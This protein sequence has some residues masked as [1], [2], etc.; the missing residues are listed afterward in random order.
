VNVMKSKN[1][2][3]TRE[4]IDDQ[5]F[6]TAMDGVRF[7]ERI[8]REA[9][10]QMICSRCGGSDWRMEPKCLVNIVANDLIATM[11]CRKCKRKAPFA[12]Y[13]EE[14]YPEDEPGEVDK[15]ELEDLTDILYN[16]LGLRGINRFQREIIKDRIRQRLLKQLT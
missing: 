15:F 4:E 13:M 6:R 10:E 1:P 14:P 9:N 16:R 2:R 3:P 7:R 12:T 8:E 11:V 5:K